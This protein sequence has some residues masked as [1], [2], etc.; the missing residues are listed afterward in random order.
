META[1][2]LTQEEVG[3]AISFGNITELMTSVLVTSFVAM[4]FAS[5][6]A[7]DEALQTESDESACE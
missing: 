2:A 3:L 4:A 1:Q 6:S 7:S 5:I